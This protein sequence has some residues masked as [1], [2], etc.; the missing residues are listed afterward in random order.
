M[1]RERPDW[2]ILSWEDHKDF[3]GNDIKVGDRLLKPEV[4]GRIPI[5]VRVIVTSITNGKIYLDNSKV[6]IKYPGRCVNISTLRV[7][8]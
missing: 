8:E 4:A 5:L 1:D 3:F 6:P 7:M 2:D